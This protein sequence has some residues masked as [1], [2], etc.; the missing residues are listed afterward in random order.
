MKYKVHVS[1][2]N[3]ETHQ[4]LVSFSS[5]KT[6]LDAKDYQSLAFD[7]ALY[8]EDA[9]PEYVL[10]QIAKQAPTIC[11]DIVAMENYVSN[12]ESVNYFKNLVGSSLEY[13][14]VDLYPKSQHRIGSDS[15]NSEEL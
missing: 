9:T 8:G 12:D 6:N 13:T 14:D 15:T 10:A 11:E 1:G 4:L 7:V 3:A 2:Y 5:D